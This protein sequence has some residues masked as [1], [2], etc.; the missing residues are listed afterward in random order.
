MEI[1]NLAIQF[2]EDVVA[3]FQTNVLIAILVM[4]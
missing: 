1:A 2:V 4:Y 3:H